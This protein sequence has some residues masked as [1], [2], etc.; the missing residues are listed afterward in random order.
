L[1]PVQHLIFAASGRIG[2]LPKALRGQAISERYWYGDARLFRSWLDDMIDLR[3]PLA[4]PA[5][6]PAQHKV[7]SAAKRA[8]IS[9]KQ[10]CAQEGKAL[11]R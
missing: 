10:N 11:R 6:W 2:S 5:A 9:L 1:Q 3:C 8:S 7:A 4:V